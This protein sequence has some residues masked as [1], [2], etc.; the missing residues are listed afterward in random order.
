[1]KLKL[2]KNLAIIGTLG[3]LASGCYDAPKTNQPIAYPPEKAE[4]SYED[5]KK[6]EQKYYDDSQNIKNKVKEYLSMPSW[7][8]LPL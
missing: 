7:K 6:E 3:A 1:M 5:A 2:I 8:R 4:F